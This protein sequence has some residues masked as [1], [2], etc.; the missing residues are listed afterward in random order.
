MGVVKESPVF[1][2]VQ[3]DQIKLLDV[4]ETVNGTPC[5]KMLSGEEDL[6]VRFERYIEDK[7]SVELV[8]NHSFSLPPISGPLCHGRFHRCTC[9]SVSPSLLD[10]IFYVLMMIILF[11]INFVYIYSKEEVCGL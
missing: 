2:M 7:Q 4:I 11:K 10:Y 5:R 3:S 9:N 1:N 6:Q 8:I